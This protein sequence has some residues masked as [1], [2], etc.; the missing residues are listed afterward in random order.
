MFARSIS[1]TSANPLFNSPTTSGTDANEPDVVAMP[2]AFASPQPESRHASDQQPSSVPDAVRV[3]TSSPRRAQG[4]TSAFSST[5][6]SASGVLG[7]PHMPAFLADKEWTGTYGNHIAV[8]NKRSLYSRVFY[9]PMRRRSDRAREG[10]PPPLFLAVV[11][12]GL[13]ILIVGGL[14]KT[15]M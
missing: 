15:M 12:F 14:L 4:R 8:R 11:G 5:G 7:L 2:T 6:S 3:D 9:P 10:M 1:M 13:L